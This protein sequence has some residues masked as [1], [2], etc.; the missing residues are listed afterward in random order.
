VEKSSAIET[1]IMKLEA[2]VIKDE[3]RRTTGAGIASWT[4]NTALA[5]VAIVL[6]ASH[7]LTQLIHKD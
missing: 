3:T 5:L 2:T 7:Y 6:S 4:W 1:R